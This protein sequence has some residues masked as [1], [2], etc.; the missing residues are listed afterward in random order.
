M[1]AMKQIK[2]IALALLLALTSQTV[3]AQIHESK[4]YIRKT[5]ITKEKKS[6]DNYWKKCQWFARAGVLIPVGISDNDKLRS[7]MAGFDLDLGF[8]LRMGRHGW[9]WGMDLAM[10]SGGLKSKECYKYETKWSKYS[11][12]YT[13]RTAVDGKSITCIGGRLG[14][15]T[16]G[17]RARFSDFILDI[18]AGLALGYTSDVDFKD[19]EGFDSYDCERVRLEIPIGIGLSY[20]HFTFDLSLLY[21]PIPEYD[22]GYYTGNYSHGSLEHK[23]VDLRYNNLRLS[24]GYLF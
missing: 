5:T 12:S 3:G 4:S 8:K 2:Q 14:L 13:E 19:Y 1:E 6:D 18:N 11:G 9:Y 7:P 16:F 20:K 22:Y 17:W 24:V 23:H 15:T 10:F 21:T